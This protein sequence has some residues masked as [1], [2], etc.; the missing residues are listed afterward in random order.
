MK[1]QKFQP[2]HDDFTACTLDPYATLFMTR[3]VTSGGKV[4]WSMLDI[5][6]FFFSIFENNEPKLRLTKEKAV[7]Q[8]H[9]AEF[10]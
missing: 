4:I 2:R 7:T 3:L 6:N 5:I 1:K 8:G 9:R 10:T